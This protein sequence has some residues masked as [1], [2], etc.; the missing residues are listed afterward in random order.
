THPENETVQI[1]SGQFDNRTGTITFRAVFPNVDGL[2]RSGNTGKI[3]VSH[4]S[5]S[6]ILIPQEATFERQDKVFL[7]ALADSNRVESRPIP[8]TGRIGNYYLVEDG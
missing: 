5:P 7:F 8:I 1:V 6:A 2:L 4:V 3:R